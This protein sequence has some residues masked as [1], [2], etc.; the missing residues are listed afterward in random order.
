[1][2]T[3]EYPSNSHRVNQSTPRINNAAPVPPAVE[4][5][6]VE[7]IVT[8]KVIKRK[9]PFG[10]RIW[11]TFFNGDSGVINYLTKEVLVPAFQNLVT[12]MITQGIERAVYGEPKTQSRM[13]YRRPG[14][15]RMHVSYD[16]PSS[17]VRT[18]AM[19]SSQVR[20]PTAQPSS[21]DIDEIILD[22]LFQGQMVVEKL[23]ELIQ[24]YQV[25]TVADL[26]Q[27][28]GE[29]PQ[30]TDNKYGWT[31]GAEFNVRRVREGYVLVLPDPVSLR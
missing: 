17:I 21:Q 22:T 31:E 11:E 26:K 14:G 18:P 1:M 29:T 7:R 28:L 16:R 10:R 24:D 30:F 27:M 8:G 15:P 4:E 25:A 2:S 3:E 20:R 6:K 23:Y 13:G 19:H 9:K 12:D 5:P